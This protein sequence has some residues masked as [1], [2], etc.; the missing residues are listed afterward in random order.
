MI[1]LLSVNVLAGP[2]ADFGLERHRPVDVVSQGSKA[3]SLELR[4]G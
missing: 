1:E 4:V 3:V 2:L